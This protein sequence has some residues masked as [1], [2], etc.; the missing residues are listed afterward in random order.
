MKISFVIFDQFTDLDL[1]LPWDLLN[2]VRVVGKHP[3]WQVD[4]LG[5]E[6]SH[7]SISGLRVPTS[8]LIDEVEDADAVLFTSGKGVH[9]VLHDQEYQKRLKLNPNKQL[10]GSICSGALLLAALGLLK[11]QRATT[12]PTS[13]KLLA[14]Y[15]VEVVNE[16]F[17][18]NGNIA[19]AA[20]CL[21][22]QD[23]SAWIIRSLLDESM[24]QT[25]LNSIKPVGLKAKTL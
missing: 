1:F 9:P 7:L 8:G 6:S 12:Y 19:T 14:K 24:V 25:V 2:R 5:T 23:L 21:A 11:N 10:I 13:R 4:I 16:P 20:G 3:D 18:N 15:Q 17:V 22:C